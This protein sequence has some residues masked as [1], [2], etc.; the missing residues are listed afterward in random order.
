M[1]THSWR[2]SKACRA[3]RRVWSSSRCRPWEAVEQAAAPIL[4][5]VRGQGLIIGIELAAPHHA[6]DMVLELLQRRV[7]VNPI[8]GARPVVSIT[9][10]A[11]LSPEDEQWL[12]GAVREA[13]G[14]V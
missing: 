1:R 5:E 9:P 13:S 3:A 7:L 10:P 4:V 8:V 6:G 14:A 11:I 2:P 12:V